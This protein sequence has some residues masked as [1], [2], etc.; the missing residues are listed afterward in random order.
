MKW[1]GLGLL[2]TFLLAGCG[3]EPIWAPDEAV[4]RAR[5]VSGEPPSITL[6]T[7]VR[8]TTGSGEH[9]GLLIDG[10]QRVMFDPAGTWRHPAVPERNDVHYGITEQMRKFYIDYHARETYDVIVQKIPVSREVADMAIRRAEAYGAVN[11]GFCA[12]GVGDV[13]RGLPG[14]EDIP[15]TFFPNRIAKVI[16]GK[17]GVTR[18]VYEDGDPDNNSGVILVQKEAV[19]D[20]PNVK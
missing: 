8:K 3:A 15:R 18:R 16:D 11:K 12:I 6:Y 9:A 19:I 17:P 5:Y 4:Q 14:F 1:I 20:P 2:L 7:V 10:S 13:L